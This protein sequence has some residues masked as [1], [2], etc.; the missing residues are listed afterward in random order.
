MMARPESV[1]AMPSQTMKGNT[2]LQLAAVGASFILLAVIFKTHWIIDFMIFCIFVLSFDLL[3]GY[4]GRLSFGHVLYMG[5][6]AYASALWLAYV[7]PSSFWALVVGIGVS[8]F[9]A[10]II[11]LVAIRTSGASFALI[12]MAF[13]EIG[14]FLVHSALEHYTFGEDG[15]TCSGEPLF[16]LIDFY[17]ESQAFITILIALLLVF[18]LL[19]SLTNSSYGVVIRSIKENENRVKFLGY[20]TQTYKWITFVIAASIAALAG[21]LFTLFQGFVAPVVI[22]PFGNVDVIFAI[23]IGGAGN[24]YGAL[25][26]GVIFMLIKNYLPMI[27][28][29]LEKFVP[30]KIP[31]WEMWLGI[32]LL[33]IVF[34]I[35]RGVVIVTSQLK[36]RI[37]L[38]TL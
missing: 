26:G 8:A 6:G 14:F 31:Q 15:L 19:R 30:F 3:Y 21:A 33:I 27:T 35:R 7:S 13:N 38:T 1:S 4:M 9:L 24:L 18:W 29:G 22:S 12:N 28:P 20:N 37:S 10:A 5:S 11:G 25:V 36:Q 16:G 34:F 2:L 32:V 23:L 17:N